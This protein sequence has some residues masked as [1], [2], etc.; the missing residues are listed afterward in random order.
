MKRSPLT[1]L[2]LLGVLLLLLAVAGVYGTRAI[3]G[4]IRV[5]Q[6]A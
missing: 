1:P 2:R 4:Y 5:S 6:M 3:F